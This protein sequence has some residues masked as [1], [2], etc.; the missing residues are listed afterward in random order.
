MGVGRKDGPCLVLRTR[1]EDGLQVAD[2]VDEARG[3]L[4]EPAALVGDDLLVAAPPSWS[5]PP[6]SGPTASMT[7]ASTFMWMSSCSTC[8]AKD[9]RQ[10]AG[11]IEQGVVQPRGVGGTDQPETLELGDVRLARGHVVLGQWHVDLERS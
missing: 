11:D 6:S 10:A 5:M 1:E 8:H 9:R 3:D 7:A 4:G 2:R